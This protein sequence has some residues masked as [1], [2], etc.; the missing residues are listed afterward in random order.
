MLWN[1]Q[2]CATND[3][4]NLT[5]TSQVVQQGPST[6]THNDEKYEWN[7]HT[8]PPLGFSTESNTE[9]ELVRS[10]NR[11]SCD[12]SNSVSTVLSSNRRQTSRP[13]SLGQVSLL[14]VRSTDVRKRLQLNVSRL[15]SRF[16]SLDHAH[17]CRGVTT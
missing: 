1:C 8:P 4:E 11:V 7:L 16:P 17:C 14:V 9:Q 13:N 3:D 10:P 5:H 6:K 15:A 2:H 12:E